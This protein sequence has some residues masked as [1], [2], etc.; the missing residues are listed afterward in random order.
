MWQFVTLCTMWF[1][2]LRLELTDSLFTCD[3]NNNTRFQSHHNCVY[4]INNEHEL[5]RSGATNIDECVNACLANLH[6]DYFSYDDQFKSCTLINLSSLARAEKGEKGDFCGCIPNRIVEP[7]EDENVYSPCRCRKRL[8][9]NTT[10]LDCHNL[11]LLI[12][13]FPLLSIQPRFLSK[14]NELKLSHEDL[15]K[16]NLAVIPQQVVDQ[17][18]SDENVTFLLAGNQ[19]NCSDC[20]NL[21]FFTSAKSRIED[22]RET[23]CANGDYVDNVDIC[24]QCGKK[25]NSPIELIVSVSVGGFVL[26]LLAALF[27]RYKDVIKTWLHLYDICPSQ[28]GKDDEEEEREYDAF[29]SY[30]HMDEDFVIQDLVPQLEKPGADGLPTYRLC[31]H[32]RDWYTVLYF[33]IT[34]I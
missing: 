31:L 17:W 15:S 27:V 8:F 5:A 24:K 21:E 4:T 2:C 28:V 11:N 26:A 13:S 34:I 19:W 33:T 12:V 29:I 3:P 30:S 16:N 18:Q 10:I 1:V 7:C 25:C 32:Y 9:D 14:T 6:C 22:L 20:S 23:K